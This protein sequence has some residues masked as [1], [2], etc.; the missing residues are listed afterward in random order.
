[1]LGSEFSRWINPVLKALSELGGSARPRE[2]VELVGSNERVADEVLDQINPAGGQRFPNQVHWARFYLAEA[3]FIDRSRHGVWKLTEKGAK[4][5]QLDEAA[6]KALVDEVQEHSRNPKVAGPMPVREEQEITTRPAPAR[7]PAQPETSATVSSEELAPEQEGG[8]YRSRLLEILQALPPAGFE[9]LCQR[10]LREAGFEQVIVTGKSGDGGIDG[11]GILS[12]NA[13][14]SFRVLFQCKRYVGSVTP[15]QVRDFRGAM[16]GRADKGLILTTGSFTS[17]A[18][19]E[20][21]RDGAPPIEL[22]DGEKL[23]E[24]F[25]KLDLGLRPVTTYD[26]DDSF[27]AEYRK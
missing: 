10:L 16:Q 21:S 8:D 19:R 20:S 18:R 26:I 17:E 11:H 1:M 12:L 7:E 9:R 2:V 27:F 5:G 24:L 3:G 22:V 14:V 13:F 15:S 4:I 6:I 25:A 23:I